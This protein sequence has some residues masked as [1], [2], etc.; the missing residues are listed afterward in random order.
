MT[1]AKERPA[2]ERLAETREELA[3][4][5]AEAQRVSGLPPTLEE[6]T[7]RVD[8]YFEALAATFDPSHRFVDFLRPEAPRT[9]TV[10]LMPIGRPEIEAAIACLLGE[11]LRKLAKSRL[12]AMLSGQETITAADRTARL[13][14]L[15]QKHQDLER[16][17]EHLVC[18]IEATGVDIDRR[19][20]V[21]PEVIFSVADE[22]AQ[23]T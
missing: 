15:T 2:L 19:P 7:E 16:L 8:G 18:Q 5:T 4:V 20:D 1:K 17:E 3:A 13:A 9:G 22:V 10:S 6:V 21:T 11:P 23:G 14:A 12:A